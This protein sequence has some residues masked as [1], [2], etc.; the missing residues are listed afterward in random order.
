MVDLSFHKALPHSRSP[1]VLSSSVSEMAAPAPA[2]TIT[3]L[4][5]S[6]EGDFIAF[7]STD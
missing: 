3:S 5:R 1:K 4:S 7:K 6:E 2:L